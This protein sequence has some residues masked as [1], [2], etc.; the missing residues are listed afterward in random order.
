MLIHD[1]GTLSLP[2]ESSTPQ[3][4]VPAVL[5]LLVAPSFFLLLNTLLLIQ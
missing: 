3:C 1:L 4:T 5:P 2:N